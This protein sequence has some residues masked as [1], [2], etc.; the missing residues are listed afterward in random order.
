MKGWL[1]ACVTDSVTVTVTATVGAIRQ[2]WREA[3]PEV[4][5]KGGHLWRIT[6]GHLWL[7]NLKRENLKRESEK[8]E[9]E[10]TK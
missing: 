6:G 5:D 4:A 10:I 2:K 9:P 7:P 1:T 8:E 3:S